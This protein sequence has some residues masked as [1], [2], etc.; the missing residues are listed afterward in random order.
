MRDLSAPVANNTRY[1]PTG[2]CPS[3]ELRLGFR[4]RTHDGLGAHPT[5]IKGLLLAVMIVG[6]LVFDAS[7]ASALP[8]SN[9][10]IVVL[11]TY[12]ASPSIVEGGL[13]QQGHAAWTVASSNG[14]RGYFYNGSVVQTACTLQRATD[15]NNSDDIVGAALF[16]RKGKDITQAARC[17]GTTTTGLGPSDAVNS[18]AYGV[19]SGGRIVGQIQTTSG[20]KAFEYTNSMAVLPAPWSGSYE[21][22]GINTL[23]QIVGW[24]TVGNDQRA[25]LYSGGM[26]DLGTLPGTA[27]VGAK[28]I[29]DQGTITGWAGP[30]NGPRTAVIRAAGLWIDLGRLPGTSRASGLAINNLGEVV[31]FSSVDG[32]FDTSRGFV[33]SG[34][35]MRELSSLLSPSFAGWQV[36]WGLDINDVGQI[37]AHATD[38]TGGRHIVLL[39]PSLLER[40]S[41]ELRADDS[42]P[43]PADSASTM[44]NWYVP[45]SRSNTLESSIGR[46]AASDPTFPNPT[47]TFEYLGAVYPD[48]R[49]ALSTDY[50]DAT[51]SNI[52]HSIDAQY[53][54]SLPE[55]ANQIYGRIVPL[56]GGG[57]ILQYWMWH[58]YN[59]RP[60]AGRHEGDWEMVQYRLDATNTPIESAYAQHNGGERCPWY[61][62]PRTTSG[63]PVVY[64]A[65]GSHASYYSTGPHVWDAGAVFDYA[66]GDAQPVVPFVTDIGVSPA[67]AWLA[68][69]G[70]WG[71]TPAGVPPLEQPSPTGPGGQK[72]TDPAGW[73]AGI[74]GCSETQ[75][76]GTS[77][78]TESSALGRSFGVGTSPGLAL[79]VPT[80]PAIQVRRN[81]LGVIVYFAW[82]RLA[83]GSRRP[84]AIEVAVD[85]LGSRTPVTRYHRLTSRT[86]VLRQPVGLG[87]GKIEVRIRAYTKSGVR[88]AEFTTVME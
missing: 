81:R 24:G 18:F 71:S 48:Q 55:Y 44:T 9:Y 45:E 19:N 28:D 36:K 39:E 87:R 50:L 73:A 49:G 65:N 42:D 41:P 26:I 54:H 80:L 23:G 88:S 7:N 52:Q 10:S 20:T 72:W 27:S 14:P 25:F 56:P 29:N 6:V 83:S 4:D 5:L 79:A 84:V 62:T 63:H 66:D 31:G 74:Q 76:Q 34:G 67:P 38:P 43:Y 33:Y 61:L 53:M 82:D 60:T 75:P 58:Y 40:F 8:S 77:A 78:R 68:W 57:K 12:S 21:A 16:R 32:T 1:E 30:S 37:L 64:V 3:S 47:L 59:D 46:I 13:N 85:P 69:P 35:L 11:G 70:R 2:E 86:G 15:I 22:E 17:R 51:A